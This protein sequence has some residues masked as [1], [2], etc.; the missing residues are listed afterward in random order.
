ICGII[1]G[2]PS[3]GVAKSLL[4][5]EVRSG[6]GP[7]DRIVLAQGRVVGF[8]SRSSPKIFW[9]PGFAVAL[10]DLELLIERH[11]PTC[12]MAMAWADSQAK[13]DMTLWKGRQ[14]DPR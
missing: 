7:L 5:G 13:R 14:Q 4:V 11:G 10:K 1:L 3:I 6:R 9:S 2:I 12:L 8:V